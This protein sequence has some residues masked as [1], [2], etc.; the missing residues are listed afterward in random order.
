[1]A[2]VTEARPAPRRVRRGPFGGVPGG[3]WLPVILLVLAFGAMAW[4]HRWLHEDG[5]INLRVIE[6]LLAGRGPVY[7]QG[8]RIEAFTSPAQVAIIALAQVLT[9]GAAPLD[10]TVLVVGVALA[11][12]ALALVARASVD[13]WD[14]DVRR[15]ALWPVGLL[16]F[17]AVPL[18]WDFATSGHEG[19]VGYAWI[20]ASA[21]ALGGVVRRRREGA[22]AHVDR[23]RWAL[24]VVGSGALVRPEYALFSI[25]FLVAW[26]ALHRH[27]AGSR[28][29]AAAW[30]LGPTLVVQVFRMGYYGLLVPNT[31]LAKLGGPLGPSEGWYYL[32]AFVGPFVLWWPLLAAGVM[33]GLRLMPARRDQRLVA[34]ALVL[35]ALAIIGYLVWIGGDYVNGR[36]L[37]VPLFA[38][39]APVAVVDG[40][41]FVGAR[42]ELRVG[43]AVLGAAILLWATVAAT[44]LRPPW[45]A[46]SSDFLD[47]RYDARELAIRKWVGE[48]P[49]SIADYEGTFLTGPYRTL[50]AQRP[51]T[52][53]DLV[54]V[55]DPFAGQVIV[56][57]PGEGPV[58]ASTTIGALGA[59]AGPDV[60]IVDRLA[61]ADPVAS[62]LP[63][64][65]ATA[66][67]LRK[68]T[69]AWVYGRLGIEADPASSAAVRALECGDLARAVE[70][71]T[72]P[73][74]PGRFVRNLLAAPANTA[75]QVP[76]DPQEAVDA[77][78]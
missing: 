16:V 49:T 8:E 7:N 48:P 40:R 19:S 3:A 78:C 61:L 47:P 37:V 36:L 31:A 72:D 27:A 15:H 41:T 17:S 9:L 14:L 43:P 4:S 44:A 2:A 23:P 34:A 50:M 56:L 69:T 60:R 77:F 55:D 67:H 52:D 28:W 11:V 10:A 54:V 33:L 65:G 35:P 70:S 46:T 22:E 5:L 30:A 71:A 76:E 68:L 58:I 32:R 53:G 51:S 6:N 20:G 13:L 18:T 59:V 12:M 62:H 39:L 73:M 42:G 25:S 74:S 66:G 1:M 63:V 75:L 24:L 57:P 29:R 26:A 45:D 64:T 21:L 38:L